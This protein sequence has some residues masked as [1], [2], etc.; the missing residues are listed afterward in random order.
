ME[1]STTRLH[2]KEAVS[3]NIFST[4]LSCL[5]EAVYFIKLEASMF[6]SY[7]YIYIYIYIYLSINKIYI[8]YMI[9]EIYDV[10]LYMTWD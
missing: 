9:Y 4:Q 3:S 1:K 10:Y 8:I 7:I 2:L 5:V 6:V